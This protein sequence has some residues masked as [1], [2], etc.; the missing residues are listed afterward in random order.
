MILLLWMLFHMFFLPFLHF[1][2]FLLLFG[3]DFLGHLLQLRIVTE[4]QL[5]L[6]MSIAP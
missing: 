1:S 4:L 3:D 2:D 5:D 6:A